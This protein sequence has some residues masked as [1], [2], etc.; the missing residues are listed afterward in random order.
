MNISNLSRSFRNLSV[1]AIATTIMSGTLIWV[2]G[3][4]AQTSDLQAQRR[5]KPTFF[6]D[7][8]EVELRRGFRDTFLGD[9]LGGVADPLGRSAGVGTTVDSLKN[10]EF[11]DGR[12]PVRAGVRTLIPSA[13]EPALTPRQVSPSTP[14][15]PSQPTPTLPS[16]FDRTNVIIR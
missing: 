13:G 16:G 2:E 6:E 9:A 1:V 11:R 12:I 15:R 8:Q 14:S 3:V 5:I 4:Q 7:E 10:A